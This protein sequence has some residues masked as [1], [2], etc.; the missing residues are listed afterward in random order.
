MA[1]FILKNT[2]SGSSTSGQLE[3]NTNDKTLVVG[4][5]SSI[6]KIAKLGQTNNGDLI[7]S[8]NVTATTI[9]SLDLSSLSSS[10]NTRLAS[11][12]SYSDDHTTYT[13]TASFNSY[14]SM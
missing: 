7:V 4:D 8:G 10:I 2:T 13:S 5:G 14:N 11:L 6:V 12:E 1:T 3:F 9:N